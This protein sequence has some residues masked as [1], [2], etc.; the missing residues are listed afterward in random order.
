WPE[1][2]FDSDT[3]GISTLSVDGYTPYRRQGYDPSYDSYTYECLVESNNQ[4]RE[5]SQLT[6]SYDLYSSCS[7]VNGIIVADFWTDRTFGS[8]YLSML[9]VLV[10]LR[11]PYMAYW[12]N[13]FRLV[14]WLFHVGFG[15]SPI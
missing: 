1:G 10:L 12:L 13:D 11:V 3:N 9:V 5:G 4:G 8:H 2:S 7:Y 14:N 6:Y 15:Q